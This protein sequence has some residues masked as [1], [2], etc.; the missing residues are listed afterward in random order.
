MTT[1]NIKVVEEHWRIIAAK[2]VKDPVSHFKT[3]YLKSHLL[4][5][6]H[7]CLASHAGI[8]TLAN[9]VDPTLCIKYRDFC[10]I[11]IIIIIIIIRQHEN[12]PI[13]F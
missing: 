13:S 8:V 11:I 12:I 4:I 1:K 7:V 2:F 10:K 6:I 5:L 9:N 3:F